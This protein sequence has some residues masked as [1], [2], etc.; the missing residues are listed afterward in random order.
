MTGGW[1]VLVGALLLSA[2]AV[3]P[4]SADP[5]SACENWEFVEL[6]VPP[7]VR[8]GGVASAAGSFAVGNGSLSTADGSTVL[9]WQ[10]GQLVDQLSFFR[11]VTVARDV[12]SSGV[13]VLSA[14]TF[15]A[16]SRW[17]AGV[18]QSLQGL[19]GEYRVEALDV[20]ERGDVLGRSDGKPVVWPAGSAVP[21]RVPGTDASFEPVG[22][23]DDGSV[24]VSSSAGARWVRAA[25]VVPLGDVQVRAVRGSYAV[26]VAGS[27]VVRWDASGAVSEPFGGVSEAVAV[28]AHGHVLARSSWGDTGLFENPGRGISVPSG[29]SFVSL[30]DGGDLYG[31]LGDTPVLLDCAE[32]VR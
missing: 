13:V 4:A 17:Q 10:D 18:H 3:A 14:Y 32:G 25:G 28:N 22:L 6:P 16:A 1:R 19:P 30:T 8:P 7:A 15:P 9:V 2:L 11:N 20:N 31:A 26:G 21:Q 24:L 5:V 12:N 27:E 29:A 23:A